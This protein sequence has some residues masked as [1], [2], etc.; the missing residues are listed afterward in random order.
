MNADLSKEEHPNWYLDVSPMHFL[1]LGSFPPHESKWIYPFFYPTAHNRFW[2]ILAAL[3]GESL[4]WTKVD[5][6]K[7]VQERYEI[8][9]KLRVGVQNLGLEIERKNKS[10]LDTHITIK[11]YQ[12]IVS[13]TETHPELKRILLT[14]YSAANSTAKSFIKYLDQ[15]KIERSA[16]DQ[17]KPETFFKIYAKERAIDCVILNSTSTASK[18]KYD[19]LLDQFRRNLK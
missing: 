18:I 19:V 2:K 13:I 11:K 1:I 8:M 16:I 4:K 10:A 12:D 17:Y 9:K 6:T 5:K 15:K 14:G 7:A 3:A